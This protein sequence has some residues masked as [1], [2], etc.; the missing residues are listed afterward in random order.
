MENTALTILKNNIE[1]EIKQELDRLAIHYRLHSRIKTYDSLEEKIFTK[2]EG[3]YNVDGKKIQDI[4]G[5]RITTYFIDDVKLLWCYFENR[6]EKVDEQY[7]IATADVFKPLRKN[8]ICR[9]SSNESILFSE[10]KTLDKSLELVDNTFE[11]QFRTTLSEGW[12]EVDHSLRY[13]CKKDWADY[14]EEDRM[15]NGIFASLETSDRALKA[16]FDD[17]AYN[18]YKQKNWEAMLRM[19]FRLNFEK[20]GLKSSIVDLLTQNNEIAKKVFRFKRIELLE[21]IANSGLYLPVSFNNIIYL[22]NYMHIKNPILIEL[23]P[24]FMLE[25]FKTNNF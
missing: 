3:Y 19:K 15:F 2:G 22:I 5:F 16:L 11:I 18:H 10:A 7:D 21:K 24:G 1:K 14:P 13:K 12:H 17:L 23:T 8:L 6:F 25:E 9:F 20:K 4:V